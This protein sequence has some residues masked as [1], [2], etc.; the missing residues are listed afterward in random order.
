MSRGERGR[1]WESHMQ[2]LSDELAR[3]FG[4]T[5]V[6][7]GMDVLSPPMLTT[8]ERGFYDEH[9]RPLHRRCSMS[10]SRTL[11]REVEQLGGIAC[12]AW[13]LSLGYGRRGCCVIRLPGLTLVMMRDRWMCKWFLGDCKI[14]DVEIRRFPLWQY[15]RKQLQVSSV[16]G[17]SWVVKLPSTIPVSVISQTPTKSVFGHFVG[18]VRMLTFVLEEEGAPSRCRVFDGD[19]QSLATLKSI[20]RTDRALILGVALWSRFLYTWGVSE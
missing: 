20:E 7:A 13:G 5:T 17:R 2:A 9:R 19:E 18:D 15:M 3:K 14:G 10:L 8:I 11:N 1:E 12:R 16:T 6:P 4:E